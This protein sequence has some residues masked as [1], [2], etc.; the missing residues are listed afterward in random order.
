MRQDVKRQV[1]NMKAIYPD[2]IFITDKWTGTELDRPGWIKLYKAAKAGDMIVFDEVSRMSRD[3]VEGFKVYKELFDRGVTLV[4]LKEPQ[5]NTETYKAAIEKQI[6]AVKTGDAATD[7]LTEAIMTALNRYMMRLAERQIMLAFEQ[8]EKETDYLHKRVKEGLE[9]RKKNNERLKVLY[10]DDYME[11]D[12][13]RQIGGKTGV[14]LTT[15]KSIRCKEI[16]KKHSK[17]FDGTL[18]DSEVMKLTGLARG[19]YYKYKRELKSL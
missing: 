5:I 8:A 18:S 6:D 7:E 11:H 17:D 4:F 12:D 1:E 2:A 10:P 13:Y 16:I 15:K 14:K 3:A 9:E 19:T